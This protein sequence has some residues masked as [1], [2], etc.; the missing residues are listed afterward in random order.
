MGFGATNTLTTPPIQVT[1]LSGVIQIV[2]GF[3]YSLFLK[4]DGNALGCGYNSSGQMGD[5]TTT[6]RPAP[7][8]VLL[9]TDCGSVGIEEMND[10]FSVI[11]VYPNPGNT[12]ITIDYK[13]HGPK[14]TLKIYS[15]AGQEVLYS[16]NVS[17]NGRSYMDISSLS[18][19][20][21]FIRLVDGENTAQ[22]KFVKE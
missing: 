14:S 4:N 5:G 7:V 8:Q 6:D 13:D 21:Y 16:N 10:Q 1:A 18:P 15:A 9:G 20:I 22:G 11:G 19:G 2:G 17:D 12:G 3:Y